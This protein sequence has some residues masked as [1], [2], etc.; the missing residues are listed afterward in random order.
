MGSQE[1]KGQTDGDQGE[2]GGNTEGVGTHGL[3]ESSRNLERTSGPSEALETRVERGREQTDESPSRPHR[4]T[5]GQTDGQGYGG[6]GGSRAR[7][8]F[9]RPQLSF[10][11]S[12]TGT[13]AGRGREGAARPQGSPILRPACTPPGAGQAPGV[14]VAGVRLAARLPGALLERGRCAPDRDRPGGGKVS[15]PASARR[16][17]AGGRSEIPGPPPPAPRSGGSAGGEAARLTQVPA[18]VSARPRPGPAPPRPRLRRPTREGQQLRLPQA[19]PSGPLRR[20]APPRPRLG[21]EQALGRGPHFYWAQ[22]PGALSPPYAR[23]HGPGRGDGGGFPVSRRFRRLGLPARQLALLAGPS[24]LL[25]LLA[26]VR[27]GRARCPP[28]RPASPG[29]VPGDEWEDSRAGG[30]SRSTGA[31]QAVLSSSYPDP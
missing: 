2:A 12:E 10:L 7:R 16:A 14:A 23:T 5:K 19:R 26:G 17:N 18:P 21:H 30:S 3:T 31:G 29:S 11:V 4:W 15:T 6:T 22:A 13:G 27:R 9:R 1:G 25:F 24:A 28:P 8:D 20:R